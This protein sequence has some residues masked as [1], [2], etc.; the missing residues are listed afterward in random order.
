MGLRWWNEVNITTG[1]S[2]WVFESQD[3]SGEGDAPKQN[4][5]DKRF[6]WLSLYAQPG[7][8]V[9]LA[10]VAI[11]RMESLVWLSLIGE[12]SLIVFHDLGVLGLGKEEDLRYFFAEEKRTVAYTRGVSH[13][14]YPHVNEHGC[15]FPVR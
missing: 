3:R 10:V 8:W 4:A 7:L 9:A 11:L 14:A 6:F 15:V 1:D 5:T 12:F 2:H 13:R